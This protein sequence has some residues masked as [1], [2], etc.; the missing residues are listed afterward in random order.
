[1]F[2]N[3]KS[4][5]IIKNFENKN[6]LFRGIVLWALALTEFFNNFF[7]IPG[8]GVPL[9]FMALSTRHKLVLR[10][11]KGEMQSGY[12]CWPPPINPI[13]AWSLVLLLWF[14]KNQTK[15]QRQF[16]IHQH[17]GIPMSGRFL[18]FV[19]QLVCRLPCCGRLFQ[20]WQSCQFNIK[21][22][23]FPISVSWMQTNSYIYRL[24]KI[25]DNFFRW[26]LLFGLTWQ[27]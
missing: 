22:P 24:L 11:E 18:L 26:V 3:L 15:I 13:L 1:M 27:E 6:A 20:A 4:F 23:S 25:F 2:K 16:K 10:L 21:L 8:W 14:V 12:R 19:F 5:F 17:F 7:L 9:F